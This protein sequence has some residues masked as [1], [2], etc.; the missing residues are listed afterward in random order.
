MLGNHLSKLPT[1]ARHKNNLLHEL[2]QKNYKC[3]FP[4]RKLQTA[5][6]TNWKNSGGTKRREQTPAPN[7][8]A[9]LPETL[10]LESVLIERCVRHQEGP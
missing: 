1:V 2:R 6:K 3:S 8:P 9:N 10:A 5:T 7:N 4:L